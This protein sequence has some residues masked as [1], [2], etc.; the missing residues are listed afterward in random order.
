MR[1]SDSAGTETRKSPL[2][3]KY[4]ARV[5]T[6]AGAITLQRGNA[7]AVV[8][9]AKPI[10]AWLEQATSDS[11]LQLRDAALHRHFMTREH[12]PD[13]DAAKFVAQ[14]NQYYEF[15]RESAR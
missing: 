14:A 6:Y 1:D 10:T 15:L 8:E 13:G 2:P 7:G 11:D 3:L 9:A 12:I 4:R 5:L